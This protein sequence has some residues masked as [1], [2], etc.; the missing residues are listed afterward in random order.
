MKRII[1]AALAAFSFAL[2]ALAQL[3]VSGLAENAR[4]DPNNWSRTNEALRW[5]ELA[6]HGTVELTITGNR[7]LTDS[8]NG[9]GVVELIGAPGAAAV[10]TFPDGDRKRVVVNATGQDMTLDTVGVSTVKPVLKDGEAVVVIQDG[11]ELTAVS[12]AL[13][14]F[15][16]PAGSPNIEEDLLP[17]GDLTDGQLKSVLIKNLGISGGGNGII[18]P[19]DLRVFSTPGSTV[20]AMTEGTSACQVWV[21]AGGGGGGS[22]DLSSGSD[23]AAASGGSAGSTSITFF[24]DCSLL[25]GEMITVGSAGTAGTLGGNGGTG[26]NSSIGSFITANGGPGGNGRTSQGSSALPSSAAAGIGDIALQG[27]NGN[28]GSVEQ[29]LSSGTQGGQGGGSYWGQGGSA[30]NS[31][32]NGISAKVPGGGGG[33][34]AAASNTSNFNGGVAGDGIVVIMEYSSPI[35]GDSALLAPIDY[36]VFESAGATAY[37]MSPGTV[38]CTAIV[39]GSGAGGGG[40]DTSNAVPA[41]GGG[42]GA[43]GTSITL[44]SDC[45]VLDGQ[46][47]TVAAGGAGGTGSANGSDGA[48]SSIGS[49]IIANGGLGGEGRSSEGL[50][51]PGLPSNAGTG[52]I[53][54]R[55]PAGRMGSIHGN[56]TAGGDGGGSYWGDG[57]RGVRAVAGVGQDGQDALVPGGGGSGASVENTTAAQNGGDGADG[58][59]III[60]HGTPPV[61]TGLDMGA[62]VNLTANVSLPAGVGTTIPW[63]ASIFERPVQSNENPFWLGTNDTFTCDAGADTITLTTL[64]KPD[65]SGPYDLTSSVTLCA[66]LDATEVFLS[67]QSASVYKICSGTDPQDGLANCRAGIFAD[68]TDIGAGTHTLE[69]EKRLAIPAG[70][71]A[72]KARA[73]LNARIDFSGGNNRNT[74]NANL[75]GATFPG[76]VHENADTPNNEFINGWSVPV[77]VQEGDYFDMVCQSDSVT[78]NL[79]NSNSTW[80]AIEITETTWSG[81]PLQV[82]LVCVT[83]VSRDSTDFSVAHNTNVLVEYDR[84]DLDTCNAHDN[85]SNP[86]R[87]TTPSS[88]KITHVELIAATSWQANTTGVRETVLLVDGGF[89]FEGIGADIADASEASTRA[90]RNDIHSS[91]QP[92]VV[93]RFYELRAY[94]NSGVALS[95]EN[96]VTTWFEAR[97]YNFPILQ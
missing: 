9:N 23:E 39:T 29:G 72:T 69:G 8:E 66:G 25:N 44:F 28:S 36:R 78:N 7:T 77:A 2:P 96:S 6:A 45:S 86:S 82:G 92:T 88:L 81:T 79:T 32:G 40:V 17:F 73:G 58:L 18:S 30:R 63:D 48:A 3:P 70:S 15:A 84:E 54:A 94:Q 87:I 62:A 68:I 1:L 22:I 53:A 16:L 31:S 13:D 75:N 14:L 85:L 89:G 51:N 10:I 43:G 42:G 33:G 56:S 95:I 24:P 37:A 50:G 61:I 60:E 71:A 27:P 11:A 19:A 64:D 26:G 49:F 46:T 55:G 57:A 59:V 34:A 35:V 83:R 97:F 47:I 74:C 12:A 91:L 41:V 90:T 93:G 21:T 52:D 65:L 20:Y 4:N 80:F 76:T 5:S 67:R 38:S